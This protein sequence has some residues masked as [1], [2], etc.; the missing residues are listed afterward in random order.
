MTERAAVPSDSTNLIPPAERKRIPMSVPVSKLS[1]PAI[2]GWH[3]HW[4]VGEPGRIQRALQGGYKFV[5]ES[6]I[7][8]LGSRILGSSPLETGNTDMGTR[9]SQVAGDDIGK[10]GQ[11]VRLYLMKIEEEEWLKDQAALTAPG[12]RIDN[13]RNS[14]LSGTVGADR[15]NSEDRANTYLDPKRTKLPDFLTRKS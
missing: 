5:D 14:L 8:A 11:P 12:S 1:V 15:Q 10:D 3:L 13:V 7:G 9:V 2:P 6:D 4:F